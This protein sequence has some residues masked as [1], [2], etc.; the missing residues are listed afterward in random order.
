MRE[1]LKDLI[2]FCA[3]LLSYEYPYNHTR[4]PTDCR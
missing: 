3:K 4:S 2:H 1:L